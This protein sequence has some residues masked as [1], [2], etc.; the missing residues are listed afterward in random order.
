MPTCLIWLV[1]F[2]P[3]LS[4][5]KIFSLGTKEL[6]FTQHHVKEKK[7]VAKKG[8]LQQLVHHIEEGDI[9]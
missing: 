2:P 3:L 5:S 6:T 1:G 4:V 9:T 8:R 7:G